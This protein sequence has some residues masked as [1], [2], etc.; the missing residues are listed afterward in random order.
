MKSFVS[1]TRTARNTWLGGSIAALALTLGLPGALGLPGPGPV[2]AM[3]QDAD[4]KATAKASVKTLTDTL[5]SVMEKSEEM[6]YQA[7]YETF[8]PVLDEVFNFKYMAA[9]SVGR[10]NWKDLTEEQ[11]EAFVETFTEMS[12]AQFA[13][14]FARYPG[15]AINISD[16]VESG[17][18]IYVVTDIVPED[19]S[20]VDPLKLNYALRDFDSG[21]QVYDVLLQGNISQLAQYRAEYSAVYDQQGFDGLIGAL[22]EVVDRMKTENS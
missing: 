8:A 19:G 17:R 21:L 6:S 5:M 14:R 1:G 12:V 4:A 20:S 10:S 16:V 7:R 9:V 2:A 22:T 11:K 18:N 13:A 3:A 15:Q